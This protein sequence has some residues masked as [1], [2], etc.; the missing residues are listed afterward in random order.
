[1]QVGRTFAVRATTT[2]QPG[3]WIPPAGVSPLFALP[4]VAI[5]ETSVLQVRVWDSARF[6]SFDAALAAGQFGVSC[7]FLYTV[8]MTGSAPDAYYMDN[9]RAIPCVPEPSTWALLALGTLSLFLRR[10]RPPPA[11]FGGPACTIP[12]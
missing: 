11:A 6:A 2:I 9:L 4:G 10:R 5:G 1:M 3:G 12:T 7:P 8:P